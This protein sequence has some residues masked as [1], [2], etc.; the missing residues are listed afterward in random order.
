VQTQLKEGRFQKKKRE[1]K[2]QD[3]NL[4]EEGE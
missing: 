4:P 3:A 2:A 1:G